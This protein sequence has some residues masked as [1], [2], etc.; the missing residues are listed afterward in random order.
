MASL[1]KALKGS[2]I[3]GGVL[4]VFLSLDLFSGRHSLFLWAISSSA[5]LLVA[6]WFQLGFK[7]WCVCLLLVALGL[8]VSPVDITITRLEKPGL[9]L[10]PISYGYGCQPGTACY[11]CIVPPN[12]PRKALVLS[13]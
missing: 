7:K 4:L 2:G 10:L 9:R 1:T 11:G 8:A 13:Y 3:I 6:F 12:P 5:L